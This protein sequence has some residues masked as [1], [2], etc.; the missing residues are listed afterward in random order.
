MRLSHVD[1]FEMRLHH[2]DLFEMR[3][4]HVDLFEMRLHH[5]DLFEMRL[6]HGAYKI[7]QKFTYCERKITSASLFKVK[8]IFRY[9]F[10]YSRGLAYIV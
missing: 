7:L 4:H 1:L 6:R 5:V 2:V 3:L 9:P 8:E 10:A